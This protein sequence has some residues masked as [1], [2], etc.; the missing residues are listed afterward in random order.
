MP[1]SPMN[2][3]F[4]CKANPLDGSWPS[5]S[6]WAALNTSLD[7]RLL[8][9]QPIASSCWHTT[10]LDSPF[11]CSAVQANWSSGLFHASTPESI[12]ASIFANNSCL[13]SG[14]DGYLEGK[15]CRLG[16]LPSYIVNA[17]TE[18]YVATAMKWATDHN[19][20]IVVKGTGHDLNGRSS[21][22]Y[23]IS[24]WTRHFNHL[25]RHTTWKVPGSNR[26]ED[27]FI[28]GSGL[29]WGDVLP[30]ALHQGRVVTTGQ[31]PSVG[32]GGYI[33]GGG[34]G[35]LAN[36]YGLAAQ[37]VLQATIVTTE[38]QIL[39]LNECE[40]T[41]LFWAIRGGGGGQYGVVTEYV[42]KYHPAPSNVVTGTLSLAPVD[43]SRANASWNGAAVLFRHLP[44]LM[45]AGLAGA[46]SMASGSTA[47]RFNPSLPNGTNG[48]SVTQ[49]F[50]AFNTTAE[51]V[52]DLVRPV[53]DKMRVYGNK[54]TLSITFDPKD[55]GDYSA[56]YSAISGSN[57][58][59]QG[60]ISSSRLLGRDELLESRHDSLVSYLRRTTAAQNQTA[61]TFLTVGL[62]GGPGVINTPDYRWGALN[63][64]WHKAYLHLLVGG[65]S[66]SP[67]ET[68]SPSQ[69]LSKNAEW[70]EENKEKLWRKWAPDMGAYMNEAN[71]YNSNWK[72]D[73]YGSSYHR[74][75]EI[76]K[77]YDPAESLFVLSG[78]GSDGWK[79]DL[80]DGT[81]CRV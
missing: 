3:Q 71:P 6:E 35:P 40:N 34:H 64:S 68:T 11:S 62:S 39:V 18:Q 41:D 8:R 23:G 33:Q 26:T 78:V 75:L 73:F 32:L 20:R 29:M 46:M 67:N 58:A 79:Y 5:E 42:I 51:Q 65:A 17:T 43:E 52:Q 81:L 13:P 14:V 74:L 59:G 63:P 9:T 72:Q 31:D 50:W 22:A 56:F 49:V 48:A 15:G 10:N 1:F 80:Q 61:G 47:S 7:G 21:G 69:A 57:T 27:V 4:P 60:G 53:I 38:G 44:D 37:Q 2:D 19:V 45:D 36:T 25:K 24:I 76:K 12:D 70:I 77:K 55:V 30:E 66:T 16:G 54:S 28:A